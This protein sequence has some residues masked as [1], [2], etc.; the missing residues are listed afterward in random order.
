MTSTCDD[1]LLKLFSALDRSLIQY[2]DQADPWIDVRHTEASHLLLM[3]AVAGRRL[4]EA[5]YDA[6]LAER[7]RWHEFGD[8]HL[9]VP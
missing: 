1:A 4:L 3:E 2:L 8:I 5:S 6:A 9:I 7:Y